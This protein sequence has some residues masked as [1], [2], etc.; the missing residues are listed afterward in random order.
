MNLTSHDFPDYAL[1]FYAQ[2][3]IVQTAAAVCWFQNADGVSTL[4]TVILQI[5]NY[6]QDRRGDNKS[7]CN[8]SL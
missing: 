7:M 4:M 6:G 2:L 3:C 1:V 8:V 5:A